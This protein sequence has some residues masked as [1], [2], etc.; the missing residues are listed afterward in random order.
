TNLFFDFPTVGGDPNNDHWYSVRAVG[1]LGLRSRRA[2]AVL[3]N[4]GIYACN[5]NTDVALSSLVTPNI[6]LVSGCGAYVSDVEIIVIN[7][8][9]QTVSD[10]QVGYQVNNDPAVTATLAITLEP[11]QS[12]THVFDDPLSIMD[13]G[14]IN[15]KAWSSVLDDEFAVNDTVYQEITSSIYPG[16]GEPVDYSED[17]EGAI[18]PAYWTVLNPDDDLTWEV[19]NVTGITGTNTTTMFVDNYFYSNQGQE[20]VLAS[21]P[22]DL[23]G[24]S[25]TNPVLSFDLA[26]APYNLT[27]Y[28]DA[29]RVDIYSD[30]GEQFEGT[31]YFKEGAELA[32]VSATTNVY[33]PGSANDWRTEI[34]NLTD[35]LG[36]AITLQFVNVTGYGNSLYLDNINIFQSEPP[37]AGYTVTTEDICQNSSVIFQSTSTGGGL[38]QEWDF[39]V[40]ALPT[41]ATGPGPHIVTYSEAGS[42]GFTLT[43]TNA[44]GMDTQSGVIEVAPVPGPDFSFAADD[45]GNVVFTDISTNDTSYSWDF[46]DD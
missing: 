21:V 1:D 38:T 35:Y 11:G 41:V 37:T 36:T 2:N 20:D 42:I 18:P 32:T 28:Y 45:Q 26:Y 14:L 24:P 10:I 4:E 31:I 9:I 15:F 8:G 22:V 33:S 7:G 40:G 25:L 30:C 34:V 12:H 3:Y 5:L 27:N 44:G 6:S 13:G 29:L 43:V 39:G 19:A 46:G 23:S 17:F 16:T